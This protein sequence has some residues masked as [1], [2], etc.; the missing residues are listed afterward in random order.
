MDK[1]T[2]QPRV[3]TPFP[4]SRFQV[5]GQNAVRL[6]IGWRTGDPP[7]NGTYLPPEEG[8]S[9]FTTQ[10]YNPGVISV[11]EMIVGESGFYPSSYVWIMPDAD[12]AVDVVAL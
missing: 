1:I 4:Y 5:I 8:D 2:L 10:G 12:H 3:W 6:G 7:T 9:Y 11:S